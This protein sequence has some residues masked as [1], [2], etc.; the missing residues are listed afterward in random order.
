MSDLSATPGNI[1]ADRAA[2][3]RTGLRLEEF[4]IGYNLIEAVVSVGLGLLAG[5]VALVGFGFDS[6][7]EVAAALV[8][9]WR[10]RVEAAGG[11]TGTHERAER[12]AHRLVGLTFLLLG[13]YILF[14]A[15]GAL[16]AG[17]APGESVPGIVLA[18]VSLV[19]MPIL[20]ILKRRTGIRLGSRALQADAME[21]FVCSYLSLALLLG[22]ALN[23]ALGWWWADP[24]AALLMLP[25]VFREAWEG[26]SGEGCCGA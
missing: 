21:T 7:I 22:L 12:R 11:E 5:S 1:E 15:G 19:V 3:V 6:V 13:L 20:G 18:A 17:E 2:L 8:V 25:L 10:L 26:L 4:T 14:E 16:W 24:A 9:Y 23:A